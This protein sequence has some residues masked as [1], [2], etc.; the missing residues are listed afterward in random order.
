MVEI[1]TQV[2]DLQS[3]LHI[4]AVNEEKLLEKTN[5]QQVTIDTLTKNMNE[6]ENNLQ[7]YHSNCAPKHEYIELNDKYEMELQ[8]LTNVTNER[9]ELIN[10]KEILT[11]SIQEQ[12][13]ELCK[14]KETLNE[15]NALQTVVTEQS[16]KLQQ[17]KAEKLVLQAELTSNERQLNTHI[18]NTYEMRDENNE[19]KKKVTMK[20]ASK[21]MYYFYISLFCFH[22]RC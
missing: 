20:I 8:N 14:L 9:N 18:S 3:L 19:L 6:L 4:K 10:T 21:F 2:V 5:H 11:K 16:N 12:K 1:R 7:M 15:L 22:V 17:L 13:V